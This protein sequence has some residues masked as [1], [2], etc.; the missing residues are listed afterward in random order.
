MD[1]MI[2]CHNHDK[3]MDSLFD[4]EKDTN[5]TIKNE[6]ENKTIWRWLVSIMRW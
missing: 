5:I 4:E 2:E 3:I 1:S 6:N